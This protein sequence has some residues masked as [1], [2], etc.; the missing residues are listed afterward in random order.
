MFE[1]CSKTDRMCAFCSKS[2]WNPYK[3]D[4]NGDEVLFC[5][6]SSGFDTRVDALDECWLDMTKSKRSLFTKKKREEYQLI[7]ASG[8]NNGYTR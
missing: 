3:E 7:Q 2:T 4:Y 1:I 5:G 8:E 6:V